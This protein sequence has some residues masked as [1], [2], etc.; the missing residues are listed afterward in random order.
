MRTQVFSIKARHDGGGVYIGRPSKW[1]N[2]F[3]IGKDGDRAAVIKKF[4]EWV[5]APERAALRAEARRELHGQGLYCYCAPLP[6]HG[7]V[8]AQIADSESDGGLFM[9]YDEAAR[10]EAAENGAEGEAEEWK[11]DF[12][13]LLSEG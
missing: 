2:P 3:S 4:R 6:C 1:G 5:F 7:D 9:M 12:D 8:W 13:A 11:R 10:I